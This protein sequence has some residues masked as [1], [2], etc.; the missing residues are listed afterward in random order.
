M[1]LATVLTPLNVTN[2][3]LAAQCGV[4]GVVS[5]YPGPRLED[6]RDIKRKVNANGLE[7]FSIEGY[8]PIENIKTG[9]DHDGSELA[10]MKSLIQHMGEVGIPILCYNFMSG[11]D[12]V[13]TRLDAP[14]RGGAKVTAFKL[15]DAE[16]AIS[17]NTHQAASASPLGGE[18][19]WANLERFLQEV[20]PVAEAAGVTL[21]MHPDDPP[22]PEFQGKARIMNSVESF[23]RLVTL[24]P[25]SRNAI[26]FCQG[27]FATMGVDIP[28]TIRRLGKHI[29]YVHFRDVRGT[30]EA[31][32]ETFHDNGPT[33]MAA[34]VRAYRDVGFS[35]PIRP[36]HVPQLEGEDDGEPGYTMQGRLFAFGYIRGLIDGT[37][38]S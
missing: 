31:F 17:L 30:P 16:Q 20:V 22:L 32:A 8:L 3:C 34:A 19:L 27:T 10:A 12:W 1:K 33:D 26:C 21:A 13:R 23:E 25:S 37:Q 15:A 5:R 11:T 9:T 18:E 14:Q 29:A 36:D 38:P 6:V 7:L 28:T 24:V 2:M 4:E 35:G